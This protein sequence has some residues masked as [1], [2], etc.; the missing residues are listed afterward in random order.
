MVFNSAACTVSPVMSNCL[1]QLLDRVIRRANLLNRCR[2]TR[3]KDAACFPSIRSV[4][5]RP[6][7]NPPCNNHACLRLSKISLLRP[8]SCRCS[9]LHMS[10]HPTNTLK[11]HGVAFALSLH[12]PIESSS[13]T[14]LLCAVCLTRMDRLNVHSGVLREVRET[15]DRALAVQTRTVP[16]ERIENGSEVDDDTVDVDA[17]RSN[18]LSAPPRTTACCALFEKGKTY[19]FMIIGARTKM[20]TVPCRG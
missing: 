11:L 4:L 8:N 10:P 2:K 12:N 19:R 20:L 15:R 9:W 14:D 5:A 13:Q 16:E 18:S 6:P 7:T 17:S 1:I 3:T